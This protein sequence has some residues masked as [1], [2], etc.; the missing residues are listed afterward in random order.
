MIS[1]SSVIP[2]ATHLSSN[3]KAELLVKIVEAPSE[4]YAY[5]ELKKYLSSLVQ[6]H[7]HFSDI[8]STTT[9]YLLLDPSFLA[10]NYPSIEL[11]IIDILL[12]S[13]NWDYLEVLFLYLDDSFQR[14]YLQLAMQFSVH[15]G[16]YFCNINILQNVDIKSSKFLRLKERHP[17]IIVSRLLL[18][19]PVRLHQ[20]CFDPNTK[21]LVVEKFACEIL[22]YAF[23]YLSR[24]DSSEPISTLLQSVVTTLENKTKFEYYPLA[25]LLLKSLS[26]GKINFSSRIFNSLRDSKLPFRCWDDYSYCSKLL[27]TR[28]SSNSAVT[29]KTIPIEVRQKRPLYF[30]LPIWGNYEI[31]VESLLNMC[32][33]SVRTSVDFEL[34]NSKYDIKFLIYTTPETLAA[35]NSKLLE[36]KDRYEVI[37]DTSILVDNEQALNNRGRS[38]IHAFEYC[39]LHKGVMVASSPDVIYGNGLFQMIQNCP[40]GGISSVP[41]LR[42]GFNNVTKFLSQN[43]QSLAYSCDRNKI[44][45]KMFLSQSFYHPYQRLYTDN[46]TD[47]QLSV[48]FP[49]R[50][51]MSTASLSTIL[52]KPSAELFQHILDSACPRYSVSGSDNIFPNWLDHQGPNCLSRIDKL[53]VASS[54]DEFILIE[55]QSDRGYQS[56]SKSISYHGKYKFT[57]R[58]LSYSVLK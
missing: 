21:P 2:S 35:L 12:D 18:N 54:S 41:V 47:N 36:L 25:H 24:N 45:A 3:Y 15:P 27:K 16:N 29:E 5:L 10:L 22:T 31:Y 49:D 1:T 52:L 50:L 26:F 32:W 46:L 38:Y 51:L 55:P 19:Q 39:L 42:C 57:L 53:H 40:E 56:F 6:R 23:D 13:L 30:M 9:Y 58:N 37:V 8:V 11:F 7:D 48:F 34:I 44:L 28:I 4:V 14:R 17:K 20:I 33:F 43:S